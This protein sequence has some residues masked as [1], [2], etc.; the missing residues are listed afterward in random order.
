MINNYEFFFSKLILVCILQIS[1][2]II[3]KDDYYTLS[4]IISKK[5]NNATKLCIEASVMLP[6]LT[7]ESIEYK[8]ILK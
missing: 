6:E 5:V 1:G 4:P 7:Q 8:S 3:K 2:N